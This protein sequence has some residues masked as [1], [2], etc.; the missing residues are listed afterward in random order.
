[1]CKSETDRPTLPTEIEITP[2]MIAAGEAKRAEYDWQIH[3]PEYRR[4]VLVEVFRAMW[5]ES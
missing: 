3:D 2:R 1:M 5:R 4:T